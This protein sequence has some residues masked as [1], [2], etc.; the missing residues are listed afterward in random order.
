MVKSTREIVGKKINKYDPYQLKDAVDNHISTL[1]FDKGYS[2]SIGL[3]LFKM[4]LAVL[5]VFLGAYSYLKLVPIQK[6]FVLNV[7]CLVGYWA[8]CLI[9]YYIEYFKE[10]NCFFIVSSTTDEKMKDVSAIRFSSK[11][12]L[13]D[14]IYNFEIEGKKGNKTVKVSSK[15]NV[16]ELFDSEGHVHLDKVE[17]YFKEVYTNFLSDLRK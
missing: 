13:Y 14:G 3:Y 5:C 12:V 1:L 16:G 15:K 11:T 8:V 4:L 9:F 6:F 7:A 10:K 17:A 2:E